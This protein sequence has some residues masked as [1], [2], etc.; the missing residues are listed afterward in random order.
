MSELFSSLHGETEAGPASLLGLRLRN[1][2]FYLSL[3]ITNPVEF[4]VGGGFGLETKDPECLRWF[5]GGG[6]S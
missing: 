5:Q 4:L 1:L 2:P 6:M 3:K